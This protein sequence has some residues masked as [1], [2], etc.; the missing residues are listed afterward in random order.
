ME[1]EKI[2]R[3]QCFKLNL[4][5]Y[6]SKFKFDY[7]RHVFLFKLLKIELNDVYIYTQNS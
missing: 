2:I 4:L 1:N 5:D 3:I 7:A 6:C